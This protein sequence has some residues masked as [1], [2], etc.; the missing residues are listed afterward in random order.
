MDYN[1]LLS[2]YNAL[3]AENR[4]LKQENTELKRR[5]EVQYANRDDAS[6]SAGKEKL[7]IFVDT[8]ASVNQA[9]GGEEKIK[10]FM[11]LFRG[12][13][14]I[15][16]RRWYSQNLK[17]SDYQP[18]CRNEWNT[19]LCDK[20]KNKC[21]DCPNRVLLPLTGKDIEKHLTGSDLYGRDVVGIYPMLADETCYFLA[22]DFDEGDYQEDVSAFR[23]ACG[24]NNVPVSVERSRSGDGAHAWLFFDEPIPAKIARKLGCGLLTYAMNKR[25]KLKFNSYDRLFPNRD[26]MP[27]GGFGILIALPL[28]GQARKKHNSMFIDE[29][30]IP[31]PD[32]WAY[33]SRIEKLTA[34]RVER[35]VAVLCPNSELGILIDEYTDENKPW[36]NKKLDSLTLFDFSNCVNIV[37]ANMLYVEKQGISERALNR[38]KRLGAFKNPDF[39][40]NQAMRLPIFDKPRIISVTE[41]DGNYIG[42]PRGMESR[43]IDLIKT[44]GV[45]YTIT[46]K[47]NR[48]VPIDVKFNGELYDEQ[49]FAANALL[50][51]ET[52]VL[53]ATTAFGKSVVG[54]YV[55][56]EN[57]VNTLVLVHTAALLSQWQ[58]VLEEFLTV[59]YE[60]SQAENKLGRKK[61]ASAIGT[62]G[63]GKNTLNG[64]IDI[65]IM[66]SLLEDGDVKPFVRDYGQIIVDECHHVSAVSFEKILK[67]ATAEYVYGLTATP[68]RQDGHH[69]IIFMQCGE[70][71]YRVD[72]EKQANKRPFEHYLVPRFTTFKK[73]TLA[74]E[75]NVAKIFNELMES[76][77]RN[78]LIVA[79]ITEAVNAG[80]TPIVLTE[81]AEHV[82]ILAKML[83]DKCKNVITLTGKM[84]IKE[85]RETMQK[86][87]AVSKNEPLILIATGKYVGE[88]FDLPR[89]DALF[90]AMPISWKG[91]VAQYA[92]RLHRLY[93]GK[94]E[95]LIYDYV[96]LHIPVLER[97][98]HKRIKTYADIGYK[99]RL[100]EQPIEKISLIYDGRNFMPVYNNDMSNAQKE[101]VIASP[102]MHKNRL[103]SLIKVL[104][105]AAL[106]GVT[107][108]ILTRPPE[109][110]KEPEQSIVT[111][112]IEY[113]K[114][115]NI[116]IIPKSKI[117]QKFT[118]IDGKI[119]WYGNV[120]FLSYGRND[121]SVMRFESFEIGEEL[122]GIYF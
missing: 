64:F 85:K 2:A 91:K 12:R 102:Y 50:S 97:M 11:S 111:A 122:L 55:I 94:K 119:V 82:K 117:H 70:I 95:A 39:Y 69:P 99:T 121:E 59:V 1:Q 101:I 35:L 90:I 89:L 41:D 73:V 47:R 20:K 115:A 45:E 71:A 96:D 114:S 37:K 113:L 44:A 26:N 21:K 52:G 93:E 9:S 30:F 67:Y 36:E 105:G 104:S 43:L 7:K 76:E 18:V 58:K 65:A 56:S 66:N 120:N 92:G 79:D 38:I 80:K 78:R 46:D 27:T 15:F 81:R 4:H 13:E 42:V 74:D 72:A 75:N 19:A 10:L 48:G 16:A 62:L 87:Q 84:S 86:L 118:V 109:D 51:H 29:N 116:N 106:N 49:L 22:V 8:T 6:V 83:D 112:D 60:I 32:Q 61:S 57:A 31:Y 3:L 110:F 103:N 53:S 108:T 34:E 40:K 107:I 14:D 25:S 23:T 5:L 24:E 54:A 100:L 68:A 63:G 77:S 17:R 28:Q 33:L 88:G 98:Y